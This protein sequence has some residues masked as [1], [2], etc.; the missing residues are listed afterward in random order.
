MELAA[1]SM[2]VRVRGCRGD[3]EGPQGAGQAGDGCGQ[4]SVLAALSLCLCKNRGFGSKSLE[5]F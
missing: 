2:C 5:K 4:A 1:F 3:A